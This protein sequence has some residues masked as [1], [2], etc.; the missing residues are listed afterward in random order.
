MI[1][2]ETIF[3]AAD[4][5]G[6]F[7]GPTDLILVATFSWNFGN[8]RLSSISFSL[9]I[10]MITSAFSAASAIAYFEADSS[11]NTA[12]SCLKFLSV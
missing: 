7:S 10:Y 3:A 11:S 12:A 8:L 4:I 5:G 2:P 6:M 9:P 1:H